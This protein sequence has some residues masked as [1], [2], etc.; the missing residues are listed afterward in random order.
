[1]LWPDFL[2]E[3]S[4]KG[5]Q[6]CVTAQLWLESNIN[7]MMMTLNRRRRFSF[8]RT[9]QSLKIWYL[10]IMLRMKKIAPKVQLLW[11]L[12]ASSVGH[13]HSAGKFC[14]C[15][16]QWVI[17][18]WAAEQ[19]SWGPGV[20]SQSVTGLLRGDFVTSTCLSGRVK[21]RPSKKKKSQ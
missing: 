3:S 10:I 14:R 13:L 16:S 21:R 19:S 1:M 20:W 7:V 2:V 17:W 6:L 4:Y 18:L 15:G 9:Q 8:G 5:W 12:T 11:N